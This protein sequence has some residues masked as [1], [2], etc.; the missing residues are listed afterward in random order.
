VPGT[1]YQARCTTCGALSTYTQFESSFYDFKTYLGETTGTL[2]RLDID[3]TDLKYGKVS[4]EDALKP[5]VHIEGGRTNLRLVPDELRCTKCRKATG[6]FALD[7]GGGHEESV[8]AVLLPSL[9]EEG[10]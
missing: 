10:G 3:R 2:Y 7:L 6:S 1:I 4:V 5:A 8:K 9:N